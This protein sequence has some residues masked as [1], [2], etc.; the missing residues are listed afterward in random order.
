MDLP[1]IEELLAYHPADTPERVDGH[2][3]VRAG[4]RD[5]AAVLADLPESREKSLAITTL[6]EATM[7]ANAAIA[8]HLPHGDGT[9]I[10]QA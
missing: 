4:A 8:L 1:Q 3:R 5:F 7:W 10:K 9:P 2:Q 6:Q